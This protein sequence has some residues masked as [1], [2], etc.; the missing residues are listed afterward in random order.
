MKE[1]IEKIGYTFKNKKLLNQALTHKSFVKN[2]LKSNERL[3]FLGDAVLELVVTEYLLNTYKNMDEGQLS[4]IRAACVNSK[5][6]ADISLKFGVYKYLNVGKSER[7]DGIVFNDSILE[8]TFESI[9]GAIYIDG[10]MDEAR[11]FILNNLKQTIDMVVN[12]KTIVDYK[13]YLQ[14][15]TQKY[16]ACLPEYKIVKEEGEEHNRVFYCE[17]FINN[18]SYGIGSGKSKKE[19]EKDAAK[20]AVKIIGF[21][22][23]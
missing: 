8:D 23:V 20:Q 21:K 4:K 15:K 3:E 12:S 19:S 13:T 22:D 16:F 10:G 2:K 7:K 5:T 14:E 11:K 1:L 6:L 9:V 18:K 17:V